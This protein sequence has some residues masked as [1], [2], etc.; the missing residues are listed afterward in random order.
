M[1]MAGRLAGKVCIITGTGGSIGRASA[2]LFAREGARLVGCDV[3]VEAAAAC[4]N[5]VCDAGGEMI[6]IHPCDPRDPSMCQALVDLACSRFGRLDVLFNCAADA[7]FAWIDDLSRDDFVDTLDAEVS[8]VFNLTK[9]AWPALAE[10]GGAI[11]NMA[12]ASAWIGYEALPGLAHSAGKGAVLSMTRH[13]A[14]E[15]RHHGI[16]ANSLSPGLIETG[17]TRG[18]LQDPDF[19]DPMLRK[20]MLGR[21]GRPEEVAALA[22]F[23]GSDESSFITATDVRIDGGTTAW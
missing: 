19:R 14:M 9:A 1:H 4:V 18:L 16:R 11:I 15:G 7:R 3:D 23:L 21:P 10:R 8:I 2:E 13:F 20:I 12:S 6:S 5:S 17:A 22:V